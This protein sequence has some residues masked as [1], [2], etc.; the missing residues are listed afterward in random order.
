MYKI[1]YKREIIR[2]KRTRFL[3]E[4]GIL[5]AFAVKTRLFGRTAVAVDVFGTSAVEK[6][7]AGVV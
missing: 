4:S 1:L 2:Y 6:D 7:G 5:S 3:K